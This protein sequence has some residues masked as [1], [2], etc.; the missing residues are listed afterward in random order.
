MDYSCGIST[1]LLGK[2][3][4]EDVEEID[5][6]AS[7]LGKC[8]KVTRSSDYNLIAQRPEATEIA[9]TIEHRKKLAKH[10]AGI[11]TWSGYN[12]HDQE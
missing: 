2:Y 7:R 11:G 4:P 1:P 3:K 8:G 6:I 10:P 5:G 9:K 12:Y